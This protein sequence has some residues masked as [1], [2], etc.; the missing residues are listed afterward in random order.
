MRRTGGLGNMSVKTV[1]AAV[2][3]AVAL[4]LAVAPSANAA[5]V[6]VSC[7]RDTTNS[8]YTASCARDVNDGDSGGVSGALRVQHD[9]TGVYGRIEFIAKGEYVKMRNTHKN[10]DI[11]FTVYAWSYPHNSWAHVDTWTLK[12]G[13]SY[14]ANLS[15]A[16]GRKVKIRAGGKYSN[17]DPSTVFGGAE[18]AGLVA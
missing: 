14:T 8:S 12:P 17:G 9:A 4:P 2:A 5:P 1:L 18:Y 3:S 13:T 6:L 16:E 15:F 7:S 10:T 11:N